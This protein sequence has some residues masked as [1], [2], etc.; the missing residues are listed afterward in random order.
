MVSN[1]GVGTA[2]NS[3]ELNSN[4]FSPVGKIRKLFPS[5]IFLI[6]LSFFSV[7]YTVLCD[8]LRPLKH[9]R[10]RYKCLQKVM[11]WVL[12]SPSVFV[13]CPAPF[14]CVLS[15]F[16]HSLLDR[17]F[18]STRLLCRFPVFL[19]CSSCISGLSSGL[20]FSVI[21]SFPFFCYLLEI[22]IL[23]FLTVT[24]RGNKSSINKLT[25][26]TLLHFKRK[27]LT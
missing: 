12:V 18:L 19:M 1:P 27:T 6:I 5:G 11:V 4:G 13:C 7:I 20:C 15:L 22:I 26:Q 9:I 17:L 10:I 25:T 8:L 24:K 16:P 14:P 21:L 23:F 2:E 3:R